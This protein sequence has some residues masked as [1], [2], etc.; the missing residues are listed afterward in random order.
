VVQQRRRNAPAMGAIGVWCYG[1]GFGEHFIES[2][3]SDFPEDTIESQP[4]HLQ[5]VRPAYHD[6]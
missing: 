2:A 5:I 1:P 3:L 4:G 6:E